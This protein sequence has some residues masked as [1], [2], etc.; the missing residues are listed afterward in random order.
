MSTI[1]T[2]VADLI[3]ASQ[4]ASKVTTSADGLTTYI[5]FAEPGTAQATARWQARKVVQ[6]SATDPMNITTTWADSN[7]D[8]DNVATDLTALTYA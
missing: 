5:A 8:F 4:Y 7:N 1:S 6:D 3:N 2:W